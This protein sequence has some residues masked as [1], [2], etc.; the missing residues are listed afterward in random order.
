M[1]Y[2]RKLLQNKKKHQK[3]PLRKVVAIEGGTKSFNR[4]ND[5]FTLLITRLDTVEALFESLETGA[6]LY[7]LFGQ[8]VYANNKIITLCQELNV[9]PYKLSSSELIG[10][11]SGQPLE[12]IREMLTELVFGGGEKTLHSLEHGE[13]QTTFLMTIK[14]VS[15]SAQPELRKDE[16]AQLQHISGI[17]LELH[18]LTDIKKIMRLNEV[19]F[20]TSSTYFQNYQKSIH[21]V[22]NQ[23]Q[24]QKLAQDKRDKLVAFARKRGAALF[25]SFER[26]GEILTHNLISGGPLYFPTD[27]VECLQ[28]ALA[29]LKPEAATQ[30]VQ[31]VVQR[32]E[33]MVPVMAIA[34]ELEIIFEDILRYLVNDAEPHTEVTISFKREYKFVDCRICNTGYGLPDHDFQNYLL[35]AEAELST[36]FQVLQNARQQLLNYGGRFEAKSELGKGAEF[37]IGLKRFQ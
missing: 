22:L 5:A 20:H 10:F 1:L 28:T 16:Q 26:V 13:Q 2:T 32:P 25:D 19:F 35:A 11:V 36:T 24:D 23:L 21:S 34:D 30:K 17:L 37:L 8:V 31:F 9:S 33:H 6:I 18:E 15:D 27:C 14:T 3:S 4:I 12:E 29:K 7:D